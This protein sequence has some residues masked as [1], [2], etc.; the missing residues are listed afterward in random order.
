MTFLIGETN[1]LPHIIF[2]AMEDINKFDSTHKAV[3]YE[4]MFMIERKSTRFTGLARKST[5]GS[6]SSLARR[7]EAPTTRQG[8]PIRDWEGKI[9]PPYPSTF[10]KTFQ[11]L[12]TFCIGGNSEQLSQYLKDENNSSIV[13]CLLM[14]G[15]YDVLTEYNA[16]E[17]AAIKGHQKILEC[18]MRIEDAN[19]VFG[20]A[21]EFAIMMDHSLIVESFQDWHGERYFSERSSFEHKEL[22][23]ALKYDSRKTIEMLQRKNVDVNKLDKEYGYSA[24]HFFCRDGLVSKVKWLI[25]NK[26]DVNIAELGCTESTPLHIACKNGHFEVVQCLVENNANVFK[27]N[28]EGMDP[29]KLTKYHLE[30]LSNPESDSE[31]YT[32]NELIT[33]GQRIIEL[34]TNKRNCDLENI[35]SDYQ[36]ILKSSSVS[37]GGSDSSDTDWRGRNFLSDDKKSPEFPKLISLCIRGQS[38]ELKKFIKKH[39][40]DARSLIRDGKDLNTGYQALDFAILK[41]HIEIVKLLLKSGANIDLQDGSAI[42]LAVK[43]GNEVIIKLLLAEG[44]SIGGCLYNALK[45]HQPEI[46]KLFLKDHGEYKA[47]VDI[48]D[49]DGFSA[50]HLAIQDNKLNLVNFLLSNGAH[51]Q[52]KSNCGQ[53]ALHYAAKNLNCDMAK[54]LIERGADVFDQDQDGLNPLDIVKSKESESENDHNKKREMIEIL[55]TKM[56]S[57]LRNLNS[58]FRGVLWRRSLQDFESDQIEQYKEDFKEFISHCIKGDVQWIK[59]TLHSDEMKQRIFLCSNAQDEYTK[60]RA[61][62]FAALKGHLPVVKCLLDYGAQI[63]FTGFNKSALNLAIVNGHYEVVKYFMEHGAKIEDQLYL[64]V[65]KGQIPIAKLLM[66]GFRGTKAKIDQL[67]DHGLNVLHLAAMKNRLDLVQLFISYGAEPNIP[68]GHE[69]HGRT[70]L[71]LAAEKFNYK[72]VEHLLENGA[73]VFQKDINKLTPLDLVKK[74]STTLLIDDEV[75]LEHGEIAVGDTKERMIEILKIHMESYQDQSNCETEETNGPPRNKRRRIENGSDTIENM[76]SP[77]ID[78]ILKKTFPFEAKLLCFQTIIALVTK[79]Q[80]MLT[81]CI[82]KEFIDEIAVIVSEIVSKE[83]NTGCKD[84]AIIAK[85][86]SRINNVHEGK[87]IIGEM[88]LS[89][90][91]VEKLQIEMKRHENNPDPRQFAF[92]SDHSRKVKTEIKVE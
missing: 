74:C 55:A 84:L 62:D 66:K 39:K 29:I 5:G 7:R 57:E 54:Y 91:A 53:T 90:N 89:L 76:L 34:L 87:K 56:N 60:Y 17:F 6:A 85:L 3:L 86:L 13:K 18:L 4:Q 10:Y 43:N 50:L 78:S 59:K 41:G 19:Q 83:E 25:E 52:K 32:D 65:K 35:N 33:N 45:N 77:F 63:E 31:S 46:A 47:D 38:K 23:F 22:Y 69:G 68:S 8:R 75:T 92:D 80:D 26:A 81:F 71:H 11:E 64:A 72:M 15:A 49:S 40:H 24:L 14:S 42:D 37:D 21:L 2:Q 30:R 1:H 79:H 58:S 16:Y 27:Q 36:A 51:L 28:K 12:V 82:K 73:N 61:I 70:A 9:Y 20:R 67:G 88:K 44:A 48:L